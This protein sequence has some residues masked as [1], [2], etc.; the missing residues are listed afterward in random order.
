MDVKTLCLGVL[1][2][3][4]A[5]GYEIRKQFEEGPFAHFFQASYGSIYPSLGRLLDEGLVSVTEHAQDGKPDKKVYNLTP[6][7]R[8]R[9]T[10]ALGDLPAPDSFRSEFLVYL[11]FAELMPEGQLETV[12]DAY[13]KHFQD[14]AD[15]IEG[16]SFDRVPPGRM[17]VRRMGHTFYKTMADYMEQHREELIAESEPAKRVPKAAE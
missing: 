10:E 13:H 9:F 11:F 5:S 4:D 12:F 8:A 1:T 3:G 16:L 17:F 2:L 6:A 7:G 15:V 14:M